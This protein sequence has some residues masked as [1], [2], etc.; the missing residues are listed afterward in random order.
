MGKILISLMLNFT[1]NTLGCYG[2]M[3][4][5]QLGIYHAAPPQKE[6]ETLILIFKM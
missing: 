1:R 2:L 4:G 6:R 5:E 3:G